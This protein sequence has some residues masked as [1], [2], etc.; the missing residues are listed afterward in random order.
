MSAPPTF[1][2]SRLWF[3]NLFGFKESAAAISAHLTC[4]TRDGLCFLT[5]D[6]NGKSHC[7]GNFQVRTTSSFSDLRP[8]GGG[9]LNVL[10][11]DDT[12]TSAA[13][14]IVA[15]SDPQNHGATFQVTSNFNCLDHAPGCR[16]P[17]GLVSDYLTSKLQAC[18]AA[19]A[20]GPALVYRQYFVPL[21]SGQVGQLDSDLKLLAR[22][23]AVAKDG[24]VVD[25]GDAAFDWDQPDLIPVGVHREVDVTLGRSG[26]E[27]RMVAEQRIH[28]VYGATLGF[29]GH[30]PYDERSDRVARKMVEEFYRATVLAAW[31]N[32]LLFPGRP[33]SKKCF[34]TIVGGGVFLNPPEFVGD[35]IA[36]CRQ[37]IVD[38]G[39]DVFFVIWSR[40]S[41]QP[42][43]SLV[44]PIAEA[45][46]GC[47][48]KL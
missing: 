19:V 27:F 40:K 36:K 34:L 11:G 9:R 32:S 13:D 15:Q 30:V 39:L 12:I 23:P 5:S 7:A 4:A 18:P 31:E 28:Q 37:T 38:S 41:V 16:P 8:I 17:G 48:I 29:N 1:A 42:F 24:Y 26:K 45:T 44:A 46:G 25:V 33:G 20:C 35:A 14:V 43:F 10:V 3:E 6:V 22:T 2:R 47:V 21:P